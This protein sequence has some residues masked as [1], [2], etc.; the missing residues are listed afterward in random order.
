[1]MHIYSIHVIIKNRKLE[2][3]GGVRHGAKNSYGK[4]KTHSP[5]HAVLK[6]PQYYLRDFFS[7]VP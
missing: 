5:H 7:C 3:D 6:I 2:F 1:M 4:F